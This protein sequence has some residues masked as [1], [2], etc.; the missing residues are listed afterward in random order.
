MEVGHFT[1]DLVL[2]Q[3]PSLIQPEWENSRRKTLLAEAVPDIKVP[4]KSSSKKWLAFRARPC[5][6]APLGIDIVW[7]YDQIFGITT[8]GCQINCL[9]VVME[10]MLGH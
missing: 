5:A 1:A 3:R 8:V 6:D 9:T 10:C 4:E 7:A 2:G